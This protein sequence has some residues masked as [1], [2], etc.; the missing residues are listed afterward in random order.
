MFLLLTWL[1]YSSF[2]NKGEDGIHES[3]E[4]V[5]F[6]TCFHLHASAAPRH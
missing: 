5:A 6:L 4:L 3:L 2:K 1:V